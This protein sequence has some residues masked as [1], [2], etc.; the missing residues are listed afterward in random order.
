VRPGAVAGALG[1][2]V[3]A[4]LVDDDRR[5]PD[6]RTDARID[7]SDL[8]TGSKNI[9]NV[10]DV[11]VN[12]KMPLLRSG[13]SGSRGPSPRRRAHSRS[14]RAGDPVRGRLAP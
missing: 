8:S 5:Q 10:C 7:T 3:L 11:S 1:A 12:S 6:E 13:G 2:P 4:L 14:R 9:A